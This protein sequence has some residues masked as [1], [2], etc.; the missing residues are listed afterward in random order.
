MLRASLALRRGPMALGLRALST[1]IPA[2]TLE[3]AM[4]SSHLILSEMNSPSAVQALQSAQQGGRLQKWQ[5]ANAVLIHA[6]LRALPQA[7]FTADA[8][9]L[10]QYT[11]AFAAQ[12]RSEQPEVRKPWRDNV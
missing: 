8:M 2:M 3:Q 12:A 6:T 7:G 5:T 1:K 4:T 10:Q 11:E 9:G